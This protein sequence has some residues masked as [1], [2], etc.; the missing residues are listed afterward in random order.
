[1]VER[2]SRLYLRTLR[3]LREQRRQAPPVVV[4]GARQV[5]IAGQQ[6]HLVR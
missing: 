5:N 2:F 3:E 6:V 4:R 1:M